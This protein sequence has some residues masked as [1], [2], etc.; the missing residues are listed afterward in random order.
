M[1]KNIENKNYYKEYNNDNKINKLWIIIYSKLNLSKTNNIVKNLEL[2][3][4]FLIILKIVVDD[5][6]KYIIILLFIQENFLSNYYKFL[7]N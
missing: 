4:H 5:L 7:Y 6:M 3:H 2:V 1:I